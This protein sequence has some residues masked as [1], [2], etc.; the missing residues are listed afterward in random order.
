MDDTATSRDR[1]GTVAGP[2]GHVPVMRDRMVEGALAAGP[3][4]ATD[5]GLDG[6]S[7]TPTRL[8]MPRPMP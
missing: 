7:G 4:F 1:S 6:D 2:H 8:L 3:G 5:A